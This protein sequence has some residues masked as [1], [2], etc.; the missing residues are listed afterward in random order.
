MRDFNEGDRKKK[1]ARI[2]IQ[3][4]P[5][6]LSEES[7]SELESVVKAS[8]KDG[9]LSCPVAWGIARK[10]N[11]PKIVVGEITDR[12]GIRITNCQLGCFKIEK[13]PYDNSSYSNIDGEICNILKELHETD[14]LTCAK[15]FEL[16][17]QFNL[18]PMVTANEVNAM[19]LKIRGCQLGCF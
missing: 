1:S 9:Y 19:R 10:S 13:T 7:L 2:Q 15:V 18:K 17:R 8:L 11:V 4:N 16:A 14:Q 12:L 3:K 5:G 6:N